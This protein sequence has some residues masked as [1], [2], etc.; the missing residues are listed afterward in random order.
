MLR[1]AELA[2][3]CRSPCCVA[4]PACPQEAGHNFWVDHPQEGGRAALWGAPRKEKHHLANPFELI[5]LCFERAGAVPGG[6]GQDSP[7][8]GNRAAAPAPQVSQHHVALCAV[9][10]AAR[11]ADED[12]NGD[13]LLL[14]YLLELIGGDLEA[15]LQVREAVGWLKGRCACACPGLCSRW[16]FPAAPGS[17]CIAGP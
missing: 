13:V 15:R 1:R 12:F 5:K 3:P 2:H 9:L 11:S 17:A 7:V 4:P 6:V 8:G 10:P 16:A 14:R